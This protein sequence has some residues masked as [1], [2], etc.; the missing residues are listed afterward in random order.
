MEP[1]DQN[2]AEEKSATSIRRPT[3][4]LALLWMPLGYG[5]VFWIESTAFSTRSGGS[6]YPFN[7]AYLLFGVF[8]C[9]L[10][11]MSLRDLSRACRTL[12]ARR[13]AD[14]GGLRQAYHACSIILIGW[15]S[16]SVFL[17]LVRTYRAVTLTRPQAKL[18]DAIVGLKIAWDPLLMQICIGLVLDE[19]L[20]RLYVKAISKAH[21]GS[22]NHDVLCYPKRDQTVRLLPVA[23]SFVGLMLMILVNN[24]PLWGAYWEFIDDSMVLSVVL[25]VGCISLIDLG[26]REWLR[27]IRNLVM[28]YA[29]QGE[30][31]LR[32]LRVAMQCLVI[33]GL[34]CFALRVLGLMHYLV[35]RGNEVELSSFPHVLSQTLFDWISC[36]LNP[37]VFSV[38]GISIL[39]VM[40]CRVQ[41]GGEWNE[42]WDVDNKE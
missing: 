35:P 31:L 19:I 17:F 39:L 2:V 11:G 40:K 1:D 27:G 5:L 20:R 23:G 21:N 37:L 34:W 22:V 28:G 25:G 7:W 33:C 14:T 3:W 38:I 26:W 24:R 12:I 6:P 15:F 8:I 29:G 13:A 36:S 18:W 41:S 9:L 4:L 32:F 42:A 30:T 10:S 16:F